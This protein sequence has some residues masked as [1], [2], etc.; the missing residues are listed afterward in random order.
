MRLWAVEQISN[1]RL[2]QTLFDF[3]EPDRGT[4]NSGDCLDEA[5]LPTRPDLFKGAV[6]AIAPWFGSN[7][8]LG[9]EVG[10]L[11]AGSTWVGIPFA[12]GLSEVPHIAARTIAVNDLHKALITLARVAAD[13]RL[14]PILYR[15]LRRHAFHPDE[16]LKGQDAC[17]SIETL[18]E[19]ESDLDDDDA[20]LTFAEHYFVTVWMARSGAAGTDDEFSAS[21]SLR[22]NA[23]GGDSAR[24]YQNAIHSL[25][26]WRRTLRRATFST[27]DVFEFLDKCKDEPKHAIY[28]DQPFPGPGEKYKHKF[29]EA[30]TVELS[31]RLVKFSAARIVCRFYDHPLIEQCY[32]EST[33]SWNRYSG[34]KQ[35]NDTADEVLLVRN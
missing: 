24:R 28:C 12:G 10:A 2:N 19:N 32:P 13:E 16:L 31:K 17:R 4:N 35:T 34:R 5:N 9:H 14:G 18:L 8:T 30:Q 29:T 6:S 15:R 23:T 25:N 21:L 26:A 7:R 33:W 1:S 11:L 27:L 3:A 22:W 20:V